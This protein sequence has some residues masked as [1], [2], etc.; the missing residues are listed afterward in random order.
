MPRSSELEINI[1]NFL[2]NA[3]LEFIQNLNIDFDISHL[4]E[5]FKLNLYDKNMM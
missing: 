4:I 3:Q 2:I 5:S 1:G